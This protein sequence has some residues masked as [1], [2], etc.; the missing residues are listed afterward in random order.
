[1]KISKIP[2]NEASS[3][4]LVTSENNPKLRKKR[5]DYEN[6]FWADKPD[7]NLSSTNNDPNKLPS[8][9]KSVD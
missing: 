6:L 7:Y 4:P 3:I 1:M 9:K 5:G 8:S 2:T